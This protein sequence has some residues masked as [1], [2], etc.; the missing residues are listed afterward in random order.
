[1][2]Q[3]NQANQSALRRHS[4]RRTSPQIMLLDATPG[5][6]RPVLMTM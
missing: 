1:M 4:H 2:G 5:L 3:L 6:G